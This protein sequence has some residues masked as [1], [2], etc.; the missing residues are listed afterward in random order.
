MQTIMRIKCP[1]C[2]HVL[3]LSR[4]KPG[5]YHPKCKH[6]GLSFRLKVSQDE[7]PKISVGKLKVAGMPAPTIVDSGTI[8]DPGTIVDSGT[9]ANS[10][11]LQSSPG[12]L[13]GERNHDSSLSDM[14]TRLGGYRIVRMLGRGA[15]GAVYEAQQVS[16]D[17][18]V[19]LKTIRDRLSG[20]PASLA[21]FIREAYAA[22]QLSHHNVVQ[23]YDFGEDAGRHY[24]SMEWIRGGPLDALVRRKGSLDPR[25]A[26]GYILQAARGLQFAHRHGM[27]HRDIKPA[28][29]LLSDD[30]IVKVAD[31]GLVKIPDVADVDAFAQ[32]HWESDSHSGPGSVSRGGEVT[33]E[34][35]AVGTPAYMCLNRQ[36]MPPM[37]TTGP[38]FTRSVAR[39]FFC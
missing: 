12:E 2:K 10:L 36:S 26:A 11:G 14:P 15:M 37:W 18:P 3:S 7:P 5:N 34:G 4:P 1:E 31:L 8:A 39:C 6:C 32:S 16:L 27:V 19:A 30:G 21:R 22:A 13:I 25:I 33:I 20:N 35:T 17:R 24:F 9:I 28:N 29:L 23:I 38:T